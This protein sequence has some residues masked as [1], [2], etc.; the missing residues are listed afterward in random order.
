MKTVFI[1]FPFILLISGLSIFRFSGKKDLM[2]MDVVQF[3]YAFVLA[4][5]IFIWLK[6][7]VF[8]NLRKTFGVFLD[9]EDA[10][11]VDTILTIFAL[12][13]NS[14][15]VIHSLTKSFH[16]KK[17]KDPEFDLHSHSEYFHLWLSHFVIYSGGLLLMLFLAG[18]NVRYPIYTVESM[19]GLTMGILSGVVLGFIYIASLKNYVVPDQKKFDKVIKVQLIAYGALLLFAY[20]TGQLE[21]SPQYLMYWCSFMF[22][23]SAGI[24][25]LFARKSFK[26]TKLKQTVTN[27]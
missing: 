22:F 12:Y 19:R 24:F 25:S 10:F 15:V 27:G 26:Q 21:M 16:L 17:L 8:I 4:P 7:I 2:K 20:F 6:T 1:L 13:I 18:L 11:V 3:F 23:I 9:V 14:F 5:T